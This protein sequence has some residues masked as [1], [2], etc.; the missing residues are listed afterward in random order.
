M[1][2]DNVLE[3][4]FEFAYANAITK[5]MGTVIR[6]KCHGCRTGNLSQTK[7]ECITLSKEELLDLHYNDIV[8]YVDE[9]TVRWED[10]VTCSNISKDLV[11]I[12][13]KYWIETKM[14]TYDWKRRV[15][16]MCIRSHMK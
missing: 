5:E 14:N 1:D 9:N 7:H 12:Y 15:I 2:R 6:K 3:S 11:K 10:S 16:D 8:K 13:C 4:C